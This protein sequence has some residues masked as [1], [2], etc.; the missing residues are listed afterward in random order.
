VN[1]V[2]YKQPYSMVVGW[3]RAGIRGTAVVYD[4][5]DIPHR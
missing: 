3:R 4:P 5:Y 1:G 2:V